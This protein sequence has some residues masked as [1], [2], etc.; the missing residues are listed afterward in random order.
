[1]ATPTLD[2]FQ[3]IGDPSRRKMLMLLSADSLTI[4]GL[5]D[6]F[7]MSRPAV[8]KHIK[9]LETA[10]FISIQNM[11]RERY[12]TLKQDGFKELQNWISYFDEFWTLK[13]K[14]LETLLNNKLPN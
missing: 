2:A 10:G 12:C 14:N 4:N 11:G 3:V 8:S 6:N 13:L 5:A 9:I 1:M 7:G